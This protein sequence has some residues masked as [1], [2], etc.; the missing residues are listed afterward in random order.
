MLFANKWTIAGLPDK[1]KLAIAFS[2][3]YKY[4]KLRF[5]DT[6]NVV[7]LLKLV[8]KVVKLVFWDTSNVIKLLLRQSKAVNKS[9]ASM[10]VRSAIFWLATFNVVIVLIFTV[11]T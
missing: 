6:S 10:P 1:S 7:K 4:A 9:K 11:E 3:Q 5:W 8:S 2:W